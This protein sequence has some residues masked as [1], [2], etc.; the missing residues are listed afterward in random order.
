MKPKFDE[1]TIEERF[2]IANQLDKYKTQWI[3]SIKQKLEQAKKDNSPEAFS[4]K[5]AK[6]YR[7]LREYVQ[8]EIG[9]ENLLSNINKEKEDLDTLFTKYYESINTKPK[10]EINKQIKEINDKITSANDIV[11]SFHMEFKLVCV[12]LY[13]YNKYSESKIN[14]KD[15]TIETVLLT[16][17]EKK[18]IINAF[19]EDS[20]SLNTENIAAV[21]EQKQSGEKLELVRSN[22]ILFKNLKIAL[23]SQEMETRV[24]SDE[25]NTQYVFL[26][27]IEIESIIRNLFRKPYLKHV[28]NET[29]AGDRSSLIFQ[30]ILSYAQDN[31]QRKLVQEYLKKFTRVEKESFLFSELQKMN[32][33][34]TL[35]CFKVNTSYIDVI[36]D[37]EDLK[38][39]EKQIYSLDYIQQ[40]AHEMKG[41]EPLNN[42]K[43]LESL[44]YKFR[45]LLINAVINNNIELTK[46]CLGYNDILN[47]ETK[48]SEEVLAIAYRAIENRLDEESDILI[49]TSMLELL[50][51]AAEKP[52]Y[53]QV[54]RCVQKI[55]INSLVNAIINDNIESDVI[56]Y[57]DYN[58]LLTAKNLN[59]VGEALI[60][61]A[62]ET[63]N[64]QVLMNFENILINIQNSPVQKDENI[65][66][67]IKELLNQVNT[68]K[69]VMKEQILEIRELGV[70]LGKKH[71]EKLEAIQKQDSDNADVVIQKDIDGILLKIR[72]A[73]KEN[74]PNM[75]KDFE[76]WN[77]LHYN[78]QDL[79][80]DG[81]QPDAEAIKK[82]EKDIEALNETMKA[83]IK[84][85]LDKINA[86]E[87]QLEAQ[88][89]ESTN[90]EEKTAEHAATTQGNTVEAANNQEEVITAP[91]NEPTKLEEVIA[92]PANKT[93]TQEGKTLTSA[94]IQSDIGTTTTQ[95][96]P[97][98]VEEN[99]QNQ[100]IKKDVEKET[101]ALGTIVDTAEEVARNEYESKLA[102]EIEVIR[103]EYQSKLD[104]EVKEINAQNDEI[105]KDLKVQ[106]G[107]L[108]TELRKE[109]AIKQ[110][111]ETKI[112]LAVQERDTIASAYD[113]EKKRLNQ[114]I[115]NLQTQLKESRTN[116]DEELKKINVLQSNEVVV[117]KKAIE[118]LESENA[119]LNQQYIDLQKDNTSLYDKYKKLEKESNQDQQGKV[120][121][122]N[123]LENAYFSALDVYYSTP[124]S[125]T[126]KYN[127]KETVKTAA[128]ELD[129][130]KI[131]FFDKVKNN[132]TTVDKYKFSN[133]ARI[134]MAVL[135]HVEVK[136]EADLDKYIKATI[137]A[138]KDPTNQ[139]TINTGDTSVDTILQ[140][141]VQPIVNNEDEPNA[142]VI[143]DQ[144]LKQAKFRDLI[145]KQAK[146]FE[147]FQSKYMDLNDI[148]FVESLANN[149]LTN[150]ASY[151]RKDTTNFAR[152]YAAKDK[153]KPSKTAPVQN[154]DIQAA[155]VPNDQVSAQPVQETV[156]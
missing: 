45:N 98:S 91:A 50:Q 76:N 38:A 133:E 23:T 33:Y 96:N 121:S 36:I 72:E 123:S 134:H 67:S 41:L 20:N 17:D 102:S 94:V 42:N 1:L 2:E 58:N 81:K 148:S 144:V 92:E 30:E 16:I 57:W 32:K 48:D 101:K 111:I 6:D 113:A 26:T 90:Q 147:T 152:Y 61:K 78:Q 12:N 22:S 69:L 82:I 77:Q 118:D 13:L 15:S 93:V 112:Q 110:E 21:S 64:I 55:L 31:E 128:Y 107:T 122:D 145:S 129:K 87:V 56:S 108:Q 132:F 97:E 8:N 115:I 27:K 75:E 136:L 18:E 125:S 143:K 156:V 5:I 124:L 40:V 99:D 34:N 140:G 151:I 25:N 14:F 154:A 39:I 83:S 60:A 62:K 137:N 43:K 130:S 73:I 141:L 139:V 71:N 9:S 116:A 117:L 35:P 127:A 146:E 46:A 86:V 109:S 84:G 150:I 47:K 142:K 89:N 24:R 153:N 120:Y 29:I 65:I 155:L 80:R 11:S 74:L 52:Q 49:N 68:E 66:S 51:S 4:K 54:Q 37:E 88:S 114:E 138:K 63:Q 106:I 10:E 119:K 103:N 7:A 95:H 28:F 104:L 59:S 126:N 3:S 105:T 85:E 53:I 44:Q 100:N 19:Q 149:K 135:D 70:S 131:G 79:Y